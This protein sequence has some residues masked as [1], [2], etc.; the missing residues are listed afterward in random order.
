MDQSPKALARRHAIS[1]Y[2]EVIRVETEFLRHQV[3]SDS[4]TET[5]AEKVKS[6]AKE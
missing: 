3:L 2:F 1:R 5:L 4:R 6:P